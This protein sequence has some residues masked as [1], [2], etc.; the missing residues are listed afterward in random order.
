M[1]L[2]ISLCCTPCIHNRPSPLN[3]EIRREETNIQA[4]VPRDQTNSPNNSKILSNRKQKEERI[5]VH[6]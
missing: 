4:N 5:T 1:G 3:T 2:D 6:L